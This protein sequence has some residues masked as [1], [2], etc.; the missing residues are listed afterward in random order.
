M[1]AYLLGRLGSALLVVLGAA[2]IV[3]LAMRAIP[4]DPAVVMLGVSATPEQ[5]AAL[6]MRWGLDAPLPVQY[7]NFLARMAVLD[8]GQ[9]IRL[10]M[11]AAEAVAQTLPYTVYLALAAFVMALLAGFPLGIYS[12]LRRGKAADRT[13]SLLSLAGQSLPSFW[14]GIMLVLLL[15]RT[16]HLLP[17]GG[18]GTPEAVLLPA[19]TLALPLL[20]VIVRLVRSGLLEAMGEPYIQTARAKGLNERRVIGVHGVRN[21]LIPVVTVV[22]LELGTL[23]G[24]AVIVETV[25]AWP[26]LGRLLIDSI[27]ARDY[28]VVQAS[29]VML[30]VFFVAINIVVDLLYGVL[31]PRVRVDG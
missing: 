30:V 5:V 12:A 21:M 9:S 15:S 22:G 14:V 1:P 2:T 23:L 24:G 29:V 4:G 13:V 25:F 10:G 19:V 8:F 6:R 3:F 20:S 18:A 11:P 7:V 17:S 28:A 27:A 26:G 16:L 31:D